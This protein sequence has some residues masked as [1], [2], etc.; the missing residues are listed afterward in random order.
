MISIILPAHK[1][2]D[3]TKTCIYSIQK[4][5]ADIEYELICVDDCSGDGTCEYFQSIS[6][7][8]IHI[9]GGNHGFAYA[10]NKG[11]E[12]A[13]P[14][15]EFICVMNNDMFV[16]PHWLNN[17]VKAYNDAPDKDKIWCISSMLLWRGDLPVDRPFS[18]EWLIEE[19]EKRVKDT[20]NRISKKEF[21]NTL[22]NTGITAFPSIIPKLLIDKYGLFGEEFLNGIEYEDSD[23]ISR[24]CSM[25]YR[26]YSALDSLVYHFGPWTTTG[27]L[28][29]IQELR[30]R[31]RESF[32]K[33][34]G[35]L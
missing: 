16:G 35:H 29:N 20:E 5:T 2:L 13:D 31:N 25:G 33:K 3:I 23:M 8:V 22:T 14:K 15:S 17:L 10:S 27:E 28:S 18:E 30:N 21:S 12:L 24:Y 32:I 7:K 6:N 1:H 9:P 26:I 11:L 34:Y 4:Y 19:Y